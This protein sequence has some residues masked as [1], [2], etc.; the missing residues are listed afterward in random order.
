MLWVVGGAREVMAHIES[1]K[2]TTD[3]YHLD[4]SGRSNE[5]SKEE[6]RKKRGSRARAPDSRPDSQGPRFKP[7]QC[8]ARCGHGRSQKSDGPNAVSLSPRTHESHSTSPLE[9]GC[10]LP[11]LP[12]AVAAVATRGFSRPNLR[13]QIEPRRAERPA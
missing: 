1:I 13:I 10:K 2:S 7:A 9:W 3:C 12:L 4:V 8:N 11:K 5:S 6:R